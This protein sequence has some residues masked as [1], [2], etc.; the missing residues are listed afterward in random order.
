M[1]PEQHH[2]RSHLFTVRVW[3]ERFG[4]DQSEMRMQIRHLGSGETRYFR[5]WPDLAAF[6]LSKVE[7]LSAERSLAQ[8]DFGNADE[9]DD[10]FPPSPTDRE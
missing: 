9:Q 1:H 6:V 2:S 8:D 5:E 3:V 4:Q 7:E 10:R